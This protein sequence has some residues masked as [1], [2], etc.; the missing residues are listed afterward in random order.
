MLSNTLLIYLLHVRINGYIETRANKC[1]PYKNGTVLFKIE[2][3]TKLFLVS[4]T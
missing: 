1:R 3:E 2:K 4:L